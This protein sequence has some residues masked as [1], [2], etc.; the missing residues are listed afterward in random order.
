[1]KK[2]VNIENSQVG[3]IGYGLLITK[4]TAIKITVAIA[5]TNAN[6]LKSYSK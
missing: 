5:D 3:A 2:K 6:H 4:I 1:M